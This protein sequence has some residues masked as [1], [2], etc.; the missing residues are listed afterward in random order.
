MMNK[1]TDFYGTGLNGEHIPFANRFHIRGV[2]KEGMTVRQL[3]H[4]LQL[5]KMDSKV[6]WYDKN[7]NTHKV[8]DVVQDGKN[9]VAIF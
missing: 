5:Q 2:H 3:I 1:I 7:G 4:E 9:K 6:V 8:I